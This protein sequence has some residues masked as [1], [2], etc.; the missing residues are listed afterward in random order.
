[1]SET[2][3]NKIESD[4]N[5]KPLHDMHF[6]FDQ[7]NV[8]NE[9]EDQNDKKSNESKGNGEV[10]SMSIKTNNQEDDT[11][12]IKFSDNFNKK[13]LMDQINEKKVQYICSICN[14]NFTQKGNLKRHIHQVH[15]GEE[16]LI[17]VDF[18]K[19]IKKTKV[20]KIL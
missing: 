5:S 17:R 3:Q 10:L 1:M 6:S 12:P 18:E 15:K 11:K 7:K 14:Y 20:K 9:N 19:S 8:K 16:G 2:K 13:T 4:I